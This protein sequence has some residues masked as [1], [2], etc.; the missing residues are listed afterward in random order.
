MTRCCNLK[1]VYADLALRAELGGQGNEDG[2]DET[3]GIEKTEHQKEVRYGDALVSTERDGCAQKDK[4]GRLGVHHVLD[5]LDQVDG[6]R[7][8]NAFKLFPV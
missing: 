4:H 2:E 8:Q 3:D 7:L 5:N 1:A 6:G